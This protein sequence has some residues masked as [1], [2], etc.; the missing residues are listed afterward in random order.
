[1]S[2][3]FTSLTVLDRFTLIPFLDEANQSN[4][5]RFL[6]IGVFFGGTARGVKQWCDMAKVNLEYFGCDDFSHPNFKQGIPKGW[7]FGDVI[8]GASWD[9]FHQFPDGMD[10]VFVDGNHSGNAVILDTALYAPKVRKGGFMIFHDTAPQVQ[11]TMPEQN[12]PRHP[13]WN[14]SVNAAHE[15]IGWPWK[16]WKLV[17]DKYDPESKFGGMRVY[18]KL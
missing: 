8:I 10:I 12:A 1:M 4:R 18:Q 3:F 6:E 11:Q 16:G 15:L 7:P 13:W 9:V 14:N 5:L 17:A 2:E